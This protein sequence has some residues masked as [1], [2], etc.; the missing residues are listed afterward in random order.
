MKNRTRLDWLVNATSRAARVRRV[1]LLLSVACALVLASGVSGASASTSLTGTC[2]TALNGPLDPANLVF[3]S[4][5][6]ALDGNFAVNAAGRT[7][8]ATLQP[9]TAVPDALA[10]NDTEFAGGS[11]GKE[12][13]PGAW[14]LTTGI[15][16]PGKSDIL[17]AA[18]RSDSVTDANGSQHLMVYTAFE[19]QDGSGNADVSFELNHG[20]QNT[21]PTDTTHYSS[22]CTDGRTFD[23]D[24]NPAT[25]NVPFRSPGD[26]LITYDGNNSTGVVVGMCT[27]HGDEYGETSNS[28]YGWYTLGSSATKLTGNTNC[29]T[30]ST[31]GTPSAGGAMNNGTLTNSFNGSPVISN[32]S[33]SIGDNLFGEMAIDLGRALSSVADPTPCFDFG[34]I[35]MHSRSSNTATSNMIDYVQPT[36]IPGVSSCEVHVDKTVSTDGTHFAAGTGHDSNHAADAAVYAHGS[37]TLTYKL[38]ITNPG[39]S[40]LAPDASYTDPV[41]HISTALTDGIR[42]ARCGS[43]TVVSKN[44]SNHATDGTPGTLDPGDV[45]TYSC[46]HPIAAA[47]GSTYS[48]TVDVH[49]HKSTGTTSVSDADTSNVQIL[50]PSISVDKQ[51]RTN[52]TGVWHQ[53]GSATDANYAHNGDTLDYRILVT[54]TGNT[55]LTVD[56]AADVADTQCSGLAFVAQ[57]TAADAVDTDGSF[58]SGDYRVYSCSYAIPAANSADSRDNTVRVTAHDGHGSAPTG[59]D[60]VTSAILRPSMTVTKVADVHSAQVGDTITYA[61]TATNTGNTQ[62]TLTNFADTASS[63]TTTTTPGCTFAAGTAPPASFTLEAAGTIVG[64]QP[65][66]TRSFQCTHVVTADDYATYKNVACFDAHDGQT[67][68]ANQLH[69]CGDDSTTVV[70]YAPEF[71]TTASSADIGATIHD[72]ATFTKAGYGLVGQKVSFTVYSASNCSDAGTQVTDGTIVDDHGTLKAV[73]GDYTPPQAGTYYWIASY[74][75]DVN[76]QSF[77]PTACG[78]ITA[79]NAERSTVNQL[80][81]R[82]ST[83]VVDPTVGLGHAIQDVASITGGF[84]LDGQAGKVTFDI[85]GPQ[86]DPANPSCAAGNRVATVNGS[87]IAGGQSTSAAFTPQTAGAYVFVAHYAGDANN[88]SADGS[89]RDV[90]ER[91]DVVSVAVNVTKDANNAHAYD[92]DRISFTITASN[93]GSDSLANVSVKD[94]IKGTRHSC[95]SLSGPTGDDGNGRLDPGETWKWICTVTVIHSEENSSHQIVNVAHIEGDTVHGGDHIVSNDD[96]AMTPV[97][98]PAIALDK[99]GPATAQAGDKVGYVLTV[100]NPG[101]TPLAD[102]TVKVADSKCNGDPVTLLSKSGDK[103]PSSLDPGDTWTYSCSVQTALGDTAVHNTATATGC[104][105]FGK[106]V[107]DDGSADTQLTQPV[108]LL[109]PARVS[110]GAAQLIAP[111]GCVARAF[112]ARV[113]GAKIATVTF[114][115]DGKVVKKVRKAKAL[116]LITLRVNPARMK[117]GVHRLVVNVTFQSGSGTR[118]KTMRLSF[119][120]CGKK[121]AKPRFTG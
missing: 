49:F 25:P 91:V 35:W 42:D 15:T 30:L 26:I 76:N 65:A 115:L 84:Q 78:D 77:G 27:W 48:N 71:T 61:I 79:G 52:G 44:D 59:Q 58:D 100:T 46:T 108:Q 50:R 40:P 102:P 20:C 62:L 6:E 9:T 55:P 11:A 109:L 64:G 95:E 107:T 83:Q 34:S 53:I 87:T 2:T 90:N 74:A 51:V 28:T 23:N 75:G 5:F 120:R 56:T 21:D 3:P 93:V 121:L 85:Y 118:P 68:Q 45:W 43:L 81:P 16:T 105:R 19:R 114:V 36:S 18:A 112:K 24:G 73:S 70:Q 117:L 60:S 17:A 10:P 103:S 88:L 86:V 14:Q 80:Q 12:Q 94:A 67:Q 96:D 104:D 54:N 22:T 66:D 38:Q 33:A 101:D 63:S 7:D 8:W 72:S 13:D 92:G 31:S 32:M 4:C 116:K 41:T 69:Q 106:C 89:C 1:A 97:F 119:Q 98:H 47:D 82:I 111:T 57:Y 37:D 113:R 29:T 39:T 110:P 99:S